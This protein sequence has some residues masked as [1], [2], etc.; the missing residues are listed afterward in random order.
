MPRMS[1]THRRRM[2]R[3]NAAVLAVKIG[4][5]EITFESVA[6][7]C[8]VKTSASTVRHYFQYLGDLRLA[9]VEVDETLRPQ[10]VLLGLISK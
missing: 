2:I 8:P 4:L 7:A 6:E 1:A 9:A 5:S 10:A 3:K